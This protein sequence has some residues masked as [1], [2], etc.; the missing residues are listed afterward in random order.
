MLAYPWPG[1]IRELKSAVSRAVEMAEQAEPINVE[2]L[3]LNM[4]GER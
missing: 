4:R 2:H 1:N 3:G